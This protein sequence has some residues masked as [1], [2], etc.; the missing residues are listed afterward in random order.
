MKRLYVLS[1]L[2]LL[3]LAGCPIRVP[4]G[5]CPYNDV[6]LAPQ[7]LTPW[8]TVLEQDLESLS[9][10]HLGTFT[11]LDGDD[12]LTVPKA[13]Q[14]FAVEAIIDIDL[15]TARMHE[16]THNPRPG[17][18]C[19]PNRLFV[20]ATVSFVRL[21]DGEVELSVPFTIYRDTPPSFYRGEAEIMPVRDFA[22]GLE[23]ATDHDVEAIFAALS[24][25]GP[26]TPF[27][28]EFVYAGQTN[29]SPTTGF[30]NRRPIAEFIVSD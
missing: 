10:P 16:Y 18:A 11:W 25:E 7:S 17:V 26:D 29:D 19:E 3:T 15:A 5:G 24:W 12:V 13:G 22:P 9:G 21:D 27:H 20:D 4:S 1:C 28:A 2:L 6:A 8:G 30:I 23:P 14:T